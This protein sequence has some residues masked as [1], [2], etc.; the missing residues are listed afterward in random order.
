MTIEIVFGASVSRIFDQLLKQG[1]D[2]D[3][4]IWQREADDITRLNI[5]GILSAGESERA[6]KRLLKII[7]NKI[8]KES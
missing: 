1:I 7:V 4:R 3:C 5:R 6:R 2:I 8:E